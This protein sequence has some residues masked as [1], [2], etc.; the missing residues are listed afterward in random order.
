MNI[1]PRMLGKTRQEKRRAVKRIHR[2]AER[3]LAAMTTVSVAT[4][5]RPITL[6]F[7]MVTL[8]CLGGMLIKQ[9]RE[10]ANQP[11]P[12]DDRLV[13]TGTELR[14]MRTALEIFFL[15]TG[16]YPS[17]REGLTSL[18]VDPEVEG[19]HGSY[20]NKIKS[21]QWGCPYLYNADTNN[22]TITSSG[23]DMITGTEDDISSKTV[24][25][26]M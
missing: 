2:D 13:R 12:P 11:P 6:V 26:D 19:W 9:A 5:R 1:P 17:E 16:R 25:S 20:L 8:A 15:D 7:I 14:H 23:P 24:K 4:R 3:E 22:I 10:A 21:D 18:M